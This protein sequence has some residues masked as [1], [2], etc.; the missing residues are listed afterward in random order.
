M[1]LKIYATHPL[2]GEI[3][4]SNGCFCT[5]RLLF[6]LSGF[7]SLLHFRKN[8]VQKCQ[9]LT[10]LHIFHHAPEFSFGNF[11]SYSFYIY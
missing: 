7:I 4:F 9:V 5:Y 1:C 3:V 11:V 10:F 8:S 2:K 6:L